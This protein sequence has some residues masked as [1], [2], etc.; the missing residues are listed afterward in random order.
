MQAGDDGAEATGG[1]GVMPFQPVF[2]FE[3]LDYVK[4]K[5]HGL[6]YR[7]RVLCV[8]NNGVRNSY[9]VQFADDKGDLR[10]MAFLEDELDTP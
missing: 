4:V 7:G 9:D 6:D 1:D 5:L 2:K 8:L 3:P 10:T